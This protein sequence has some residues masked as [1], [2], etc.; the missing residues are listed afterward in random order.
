MPLL[1]QIRETKLIEMAKTRFD[2]D[3]TPAELKVLHDSASSEEVPDPG[4][5]APRPEVRA[6]FL[7]WLA[8]DPE[9][10]QHIDPKGLRVYAATIPGNLD[11]RECHVNPTL[12]FRHC[13]FQ[14]AIDLRSAETRGLFFLDSSLV[15]GMSADR[16]MVH[17]PL[18]LRPI[19]SEGE[20]R[21]PGPR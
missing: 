5:K 1:D 15:G 16:A 14:G 21:L 20:I 2:P 18:F 19:V 7:R 11:L 9:A 4:E 13:V 10:V 6:A 8:T 12:D 17:G 3:P